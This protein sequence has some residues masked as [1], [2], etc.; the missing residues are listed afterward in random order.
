MEKYR[1]DW[2]NQYYMYVYYPKTL[3]LSLVANNDNDSNK[4]NG[5]G[6]HLLK[7]RSIHKN[8]FPKTCFIA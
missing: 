4:N 7:T 5:Y 3:G 2:Q 8:S 1:E 6:K